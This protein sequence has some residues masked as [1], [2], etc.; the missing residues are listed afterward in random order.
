MGSKE[1]MLSLQ[2]KLPRGFESKDRVRSWFCLVLIFLE[3]ASFPIGLSPRTMQ[4]LGS[5]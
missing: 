5:V 1:K 3:V 4:N 2:C